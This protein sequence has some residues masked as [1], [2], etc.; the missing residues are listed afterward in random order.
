MGSVTRQQVIFSDASPVG[1]GAVHEG[2]GV[3]G[4]WSGP[5]LS[6]YIN[7]L[8]LPAV[9]LALRHFLPQLQGFHLIVR[10]DSTVAAAYV[11]C[12]GGL[13]FPPL[14]KLATKLWLW[15]HP[16]FLTLRVVHVPGPLNTAADIMSRGGPS[17]GEWRLH[18]QVVDRIWCR[19]GRVA[20]SRDSNHCPQFFSPRADEPPLP[21][22]SLPSP[23]LLPEVRLILVAP[24]WPHMP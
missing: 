3:S 9:F 10:M 6:R 17:H 7:V 5:W 18:P 8:E 21:T 16:R 1:W 23:S 20:V 12:Q 4:R 14:C 24:L 2:C 19:F 11:N 13:G 22:L 15:A